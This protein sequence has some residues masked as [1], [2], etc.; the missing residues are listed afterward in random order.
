MSNPSADAAYAERY[1]RHILLKEIGG[2]GQK[3]LAAARI[4]LIGAGGLGAPALLYLAAAGVGFIRVVDPD[5]VTLSNLGRQIAFR[6]A[7]I[8][9]PKAPTAVAAARA[10]N[11]GTVIEAAVA[12]FSAENAAALAGDCAILLDATDNFATRHALNLYCHARG[13]TLISGALGRW[14]GQLATFKSG[15][16]AAHGAPLSPCYRCFAPEAPDEAEFCARDGVVG[17]L[18]GVIGA[19]MALETVKEITGAGESLAGRILLYDGLAAR[20]RVVRLVPDP[21]CPVCGDDTSKSGPAQ[22]A[23]N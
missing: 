11:P 14:D 22:A 7:E 16:A 9:L 23:A 3:K 13:K 19:A 6:T 4:A 12:V 1:S 21:A 18:A 2:P 17:A 5:R 8:G 10:L 15:L 20:A